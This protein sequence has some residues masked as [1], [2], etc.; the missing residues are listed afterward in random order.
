MAAGAR[1]SE[2]AVA[3]ERVLIHQQTDDVGK[4]GPERGKNF[5]ALNVEVAPVGDRRCGQPTDES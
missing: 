5:K 2:C 3:R 4:I 1:D